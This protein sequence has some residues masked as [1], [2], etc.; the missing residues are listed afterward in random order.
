MRMCRARS[1]PPLTSVQR[2]GRSELCAFERVSLVS[3]VLQTGLDTASLRSACA[4]APVKSTAWCRTGSKCLQSRCAE[5]DG[6]RVPILVGDM[7]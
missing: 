2:Q 4:L 7:L 5:G 6:I 3:I 1:A